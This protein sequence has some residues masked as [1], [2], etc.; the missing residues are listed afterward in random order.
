MMKSG[1]GSDG[2]KPAAKS[3]KRRGR[4]MRGR[5]PMP[6]GETIGGVQWLEKGW[7]LATTVSA[8]DTEWVVYE[9]T[10]ASREWLDIRV[11]AKYGA[12][13]KASYWLSWSYREERFAR[14]KDAILMAEHRPLLRDAVGAY[15]KTPAASGDPSKAI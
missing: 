5:H 10:A 8:Y 12:R 6:T 15:L 3:R 14:L 2:E 13:D 1:K 4:F 11:I 9:R 7:L